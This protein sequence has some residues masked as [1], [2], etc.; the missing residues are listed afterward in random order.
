M[1][2]QKE[3]ERVPSLDLEHRCKQKEKSMG[4]I[5]ST[6]LGYISATIRLS[7]LAPVRFSLF[8]Y[9]WVRNITFCW[10]F[11]LDRFRFDFGFDSFLFRA[12][13][14]PMKIFVFSIFRFILISLSLS[15][16]SKICI[17]SFSSFFLFLFFFLGF[18]FGKHLLICFTGLVDTT[19]VWY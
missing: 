2:I 17:H 6:P 11:S 12:F 7:E 4:I 19:P 5:A 16:F 8:F 14:F 13:G 9:V 3:K 1:Q 15:L 10:L 18:W